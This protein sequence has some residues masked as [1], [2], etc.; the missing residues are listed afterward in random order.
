AGLAGG[1]RLTALTGCPCGCSGPGDPLCVTRRP[2]GPAV[3]YSAQYGVE[4]DPFADITD[5]DAAAARAYW[6]AQD[7]AA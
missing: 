7:V 4:A 1:G 3:D 2:I 5:E 6:Y